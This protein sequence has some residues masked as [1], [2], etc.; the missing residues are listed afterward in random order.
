MIG[1]MQGRL[2]P[3]LAGDLQFFP[4]DNW[5]NEFLIASKN[6][7]NLIEWTIDSF[8]IEKNPFFKFYDEILNLS[9]KFNISIKS[10]TCD[11]LMECPFYKENKENEIDSLYFL[12]ETINF[13]KKLG[14]KFIIFPLVDNGS[15]KNSKELDFFFNGIRTIESSL[16]KNTQIIF[17]TDF[18]PVKQLRFI[19]NFCSTKFGIN[20]DTGNSAYNGYDTIDELTTYYDYIKNIHIK[21]RRFKV[22]TFYKT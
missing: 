9:S 4:W 11:F 3:S 20:Y 7:F 16:S 14:V 2:T 19:K 22:D 13:S 12:N 15:I 5:K 1:F 8:D 18:A 10:V 17:E 21:D 6:N